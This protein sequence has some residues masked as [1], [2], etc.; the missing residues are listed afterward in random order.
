M[1]YVRMVGCCLDY[2]IEDY[3][4]LEDNGFLIM[5]KAAGEVVGLVSS[6][7]EV[8][9]IKNSVSASSYSATLSNFIVKSVSE[10]PSIATHLFR[11]KIDVYHRGKEIIDFGHKYIINMKNGK[12]YEKIN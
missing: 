10:V 12:I 9:E 6:W 5:D 7:E 1:I 11:E 8:N 3:I 2:T 4:Y